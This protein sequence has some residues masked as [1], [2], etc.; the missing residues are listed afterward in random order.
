MIRKRSTPPIKAAVDHKGR[1][2]GDPGPHRQ[3]LR[4]GRG[5]RRPQ[6]HA[7]AEEAERGRTEGIPQRAS[8]FPSPTRTWPSAPSIKP[9]EDSRELQYMRERRQELGGSLAGPRS[10]MP[11]PGGSAAWKR[12]GPSSRAAA[13]RTSSTTAGLCRHAQACCWSDKEHRQVRSCRSSPTKPAPS[14][15]T[16]SSPVR[17]LLQRRPALR[18]GRRQHAAGLSRGQERA[19]A[20]RRHHR[21]GGDVVLHRRGHRLCHARHADD[22]LLHLLLD[23]RLPADRRSDL[24]GRG[25]AAR[26]G[27]LLGGTAGR[28]TLNGEGLAARGRP[29]PSAGLDG[30][31]LCGLRPGLC[32]RAGRHHPGR[33][34]PHVSRP[35][36]D[37]FYYIT[38]YNENYPMPPMPEGAAEGILRGLYKLR[39]A[40]ASQAKGTKVHLFGSGPILREPC[41]LRKCWPSSSAWP[42]TSG[43]RPV[44]RNCAAMLWKPNAG[45]CCTPSN[46]RGSYVESAA[47]E[48]GVFL[49][50]SDY[51]RPVPEM[52][53]RWV[54]GG[55]RCWARMALAA[56]KAGRPCGVSS[57]SMPSASPWRLYTS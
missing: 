26:A 38:L 2:D 52:I 1:T 39:P 55:L 50:A 18:T 37:V 35:S 41:G 10:R 51:M 9:A 3:G 29:Q 53:E 46:R 13:T 24:G 4:A 12:S 17:H 56:A 14:A 42:P 25:H 8:A 28:T 43:A 57:R 31:E 40:T 20:R 7:S 16:R 23:V 36:E 19:D 47:E 5:R 22:S 27:F 15:W 30:A 21:G 54:P 48:Q 11:A 32:L 6:H 49:A 45:T 34:S 44:T 33:H